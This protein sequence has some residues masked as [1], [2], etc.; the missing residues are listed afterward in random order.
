[1]GKHK[2]QTKYVRTNQKSHFGNNCPLSFVDWATMLWFLADAM[3]H[4]F[5][6]GSYLFYAFMGGAKHFD[7]LV[8]WIWKEYSKAD[9][10]WEVRDSTV[11]S[12]E[13]LT[14]CIEGPLC[15]VMIYAI[16]N[17]LSYRHFMQTCIS[18]AEIYGG[19]M[20]FF[21][22][23]IDGNPNLDT[24][25]W[26]Y[27]WFYLAFMNG[28]WVVIPAILLCESGIRIIDACDKTEQFDQGGLPPA[29]HKLCLA[30]LIIYSCSVPAVVM[31]Q[32]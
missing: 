13:L 6:E 25:S 21:P 29:W 32:Y 31:L 24:T 20:T 28:V 10:R 26:K 1:M 7:G 5:M 9:R 17:R 22:E 8:P 16:Y 2:E 19:C 3:T 23:W 15:L 12:I 30:V 11:M 27:K 4:I 18:L 14:V